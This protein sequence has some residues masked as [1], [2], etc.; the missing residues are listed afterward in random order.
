MPNWRA[1]GKNTTGRNGSSSPTGS[2]PRIL[3]PSWH[4]IGRGIVLRLLIPLCWISRWAY[5][6]DTWTNPLTPRSVRN[7]SIFCCGDA[8][9]RMPGGKREMS[10]LGLVWA[11]LW[12]YMHKVVSFPGSC[13]W[14]SISLPMQLLKRNT[15]YWKNSWFK[16][17]CVNSIENSLQCT[18]YQIS[19]NI[20]NLP[21]RIHLSKLRKVPLVTM[22]LTP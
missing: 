18:L 1:N 17:S 5:L 19:L 10:E 13:L 14:S 11:H 22:L 20:N 6:W 21:N 15:L 8:F 4:D 3:N 16:E 9:Y 2:S 12:M 7:S